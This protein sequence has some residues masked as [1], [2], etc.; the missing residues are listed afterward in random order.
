MLERP[1]L[2][3]MRRKLHVPKQGEEATTAKW[4]NGNL[5]WTR[6]LLQTIVVANLYWDHEPYSLH[7]LP[8]LVQSCICE[9]MVLMSNINKNHWI[10]D[11]WGGSLTNARYPTF[12]VNG[13]QGTR[14]ILRAMN[15][16]VEVEWTVEFFCQETLMN[17]LSNWQGYLPLRH[18]GSQ[19]P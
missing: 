3:P 16:F 9:Y 7:P 11:H 2:P 14:Y 8:I 12:D 1:L 10:A 18:A 13:N 17:F 19:V 15:R 5:Y 4:L 6:K